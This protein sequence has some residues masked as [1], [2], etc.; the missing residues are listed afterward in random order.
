M[1]N[2]HNCYDFGLILIKEMARPEGSSELAEIASRAEPSE[3]I[4]VQPRE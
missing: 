1:Q 2:R 3:S 4:H